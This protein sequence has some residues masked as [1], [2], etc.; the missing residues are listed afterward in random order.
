MPLAYGRLTQARDRML[1]TPSK[2]IKI[3]GRTIK[4]T[5]T[6]QERKLLLSGH[7]DAKVNKRDA[8]IVCYVA[9]LECKFG[10]TV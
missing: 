9:S 10:K 8:Q 7:K 6:R 4:Y 3:S 1:K 2:I 5:E